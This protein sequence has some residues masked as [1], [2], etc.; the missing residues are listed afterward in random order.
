[1]AKSRRRRRPKARQRRPQQTTTKTEITLA[2]LALWI[3]LGISI[4]FALQPWM[5]IGEIAVDRIH[6]IPFY[7]V[8]SKVPVLNGILF[9]FEDI[10][11]NTAVSIVGVALCLTINITQ[12]VN[13]MQATML[14]WIIRC[15][16]GLF[17]LLVSV[18]Y[19]A[20]YDGGIEAL[21]ADF[22]YLDPYYVN[23]QGAMMTAISVL[24]FEVLFLYGHEYIRQMK[25]QYES[26]QKKLEGRGNGRQTQ[27]A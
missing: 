14:Q 2:T 4:V 24:L 23:V 16:G 6:A 8:L 20:P 27:Q 19:H 22:P 7:G 17:E 5:A 10:A 25:S 12:V 18:Y 26:Q 21:L 15:I 3:L 13:G 9:F 1:M 11:N